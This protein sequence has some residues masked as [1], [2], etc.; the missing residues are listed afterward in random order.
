MIW[1]AE[2]ISGGAGARGVRRQA[3]RR[4]R[5]WPHENA[6]QRAPRA[7]MLSR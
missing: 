5:F 1:S 4:T 6:A 7:P 3:M 2:R